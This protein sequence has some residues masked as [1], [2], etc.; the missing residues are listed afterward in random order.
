M[1][2]ITVVMVV[3]RHWLFLINRH[4]RIYFPGVDDGAF[5]KV[6]ND[7]IVLHGNGGDIELGTAGQATW[8][9]Q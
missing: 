5:R 1:T 3:F 7:E 9:G 2:M 6:D 4:S 8:R